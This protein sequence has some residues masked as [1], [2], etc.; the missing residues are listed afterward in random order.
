MSGAT[1]SFIQRARE[2]GL[3]TALGTVVPRAVHCPIFLENG[4]F[5]GLA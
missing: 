3:V 2:E 5:A 1:A 4:V